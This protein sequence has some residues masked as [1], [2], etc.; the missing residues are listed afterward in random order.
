MLKTYLI[1]QIAQTQ[2]GIW[3][4]MPGAAVSGRRKGHA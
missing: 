1:R 4:R 3:M 2:V